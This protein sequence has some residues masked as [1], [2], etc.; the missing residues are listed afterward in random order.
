MGDRVEIEMEDGEIVYCELLDFAPEECDR[1]ACP[2]AHMCN[3]DE[4]KLEER[5]EFKCLVCGEKMEYDEF[6]DYGGRCKECRKG[7]EFVD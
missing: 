3:L 4:D 2:F 1:D 6:A 7:E 5:K